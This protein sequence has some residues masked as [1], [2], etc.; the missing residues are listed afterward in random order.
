[1]GTFGYLHP[2]YFQSSQFT[3]KRDVY[4]FG[5]VLVELLTGQKAIRSAIQED[6]SLVSWFL[7]HLENSNLLV[8]I[9]SQVLQE[10]SKAEFLTIAII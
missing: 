4:S 6:R 5:V 7:S 3:E 8:I 9:D 1:M 10:G 2:E